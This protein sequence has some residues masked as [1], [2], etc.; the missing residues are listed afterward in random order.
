MSSSL[1][2]AVSTAVSGRLRFRLLVGA[3]CSGLLIALACSRGGSGTPPSTDS[4]APTTVQAA[5]GR[6]NI[7]GTQKP[8]YS[9]GKEE[10]IIRDFFQDR[11]EGFFVDVGCWHPI[12]D[13]N[14][15]FLEHHLGW[16]G[17]GID[18]LPEMARKWKRRRPRSRFFNFLVTD[19][20]DTVDPF[21]R[22]EY[23]DISGIDKPDPARKLKWEQIEVPSVTLDKLLDANGVTKIDLLSM[24]I[25]GAEPLALAGFDIDRFKPELACLEAKVK[26]REAI[27]TYF[28][29]HN[30]AQIERYLEYD[31]VN[32]YFTPRSTHR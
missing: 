6:K 17:I 4:P 11:R 31:R 19:H 30:Y 26:S 7:V 24:D 12:S 3:S 9:H 27:R 25:E 21:Y 13:N 2:A 10:I 28:A 18:A 32:W 29:R 22:I 16:S 15:Y 23:T 8:L 5:T 20:S 1:S 14:T